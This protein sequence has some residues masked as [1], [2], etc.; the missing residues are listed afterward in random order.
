MYDLLSSGSVDGSARSQRRGQKRPG[1]FDPIQSLWDM[2]GAPEDSLQQ[3][4]DYLNR[5]GQDYSRYTGQAEDLLSNPPQI[6]LNP[7][8]GKLG[9]Y[10]DSLLGSASQYE[11]QLGGYAD[12]ANQYA[13]GM[14]DSSLSSA[15]QMESASKKGLEESMGSYRSMLNLS[16]DLARRDMPGMDLYRGR[17]GSQTSQ[18]IQQLKDIGGLSSGTFQSAVTGQNE[19]LRDL[20]LQSSMYKAQQQQNLA[21][22][23][24]QYGQMAQSAYNSRVAGLGQAAGVRGQGY[25]GAAGI[26]QGLGLGATAAAANLMQGAYQ[27]AG[28]MTGAQA[29]LEGQQF[30]YNQFAPWQTNVGYNQGMAQQSSPYE[31]GMNWYGGLYANQSAQRAAAM[32]G[33]MDMISGFQQQGQA[34]AKTFLTG[35]M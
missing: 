25:T 27:G 29:G 21:G 30:Y 18:N 33:F 6:D 8:I 24:G 9:G 5:M 12:L 11:Q 22:A 31:S 14:L 23:Y 4:E 15:S 20:A 2:I 7:Y 26:Q 19:Q 17:I 28:A 34:M 10:I 13:E 35:G 3:G 32:Q 16:K 1:F